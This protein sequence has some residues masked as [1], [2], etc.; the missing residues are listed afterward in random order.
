MKTLRPQ[1]LSHP[2][3]QFLSD[4][5]PKFFEPDENTRW[6]KVLGISMGRIF[7]TYRANFLK[8]CFI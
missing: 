3:T 1:T 7:S 6:Y 4:G 8:R 2:I 5:E